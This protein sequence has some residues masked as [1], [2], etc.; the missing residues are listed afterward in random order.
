VVP[1]RGCLDNRPIVWSFIHKGGIME[2]TLPLTA[3]ARIV[4]RVEC[5][6]LSNPAERKF[7]TYELFS[8]KEK[9]LEDIQYF[10]EE[11]LKQIR[12][13]GE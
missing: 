4:V 10:L 7:G 2:K 3:F 6:K 13:G 1:C 12:E 8:K 11:V 9:A 5:K